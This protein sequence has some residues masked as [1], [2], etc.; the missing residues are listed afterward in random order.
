M[1]KT[2]CPLCGGDNNCEN[3]NACWCYKVVVPKELLELVPDDKR[4][5]SC[6]CKSC[7]DKYNR[8]KTIKGDDS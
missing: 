6:I 1:E 4:G 7:I 3:R 8:K 2:I 5:K